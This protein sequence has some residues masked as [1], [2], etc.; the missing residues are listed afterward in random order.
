MLK[1][2]YCT[3]PTTKHLRC[4][5]GAQATDD[6]Q[7]E[8]GSLV[9]GQV[10]ESLDYLHCGHTVQGLVLSIAAFDVRHRLDQRD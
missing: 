9:I 4:L 2:P 6:S 1:R 3:G 7:G 5:L 10:A 8:H